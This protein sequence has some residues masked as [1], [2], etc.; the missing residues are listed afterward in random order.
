MPRRG[1]SFDV[2]R[3]CVVEPAR[4]RRIWGGSRQIVG[5][6][7]T[8]QYRGL[9]V[10]WRSRGRLRLGPGEI[11]LK[12][13]SPGFGVIWP[14]PRTGP[15][16]EVILALRSDCLWLSRGEPS[17]YCRDGSPWL[18][19]MCGAEIGIGAYYRSPMS[20]KNLMVSSLRWLIRPKM[21]SSSARDRIRDGL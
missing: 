20:R 19:L 2:P 12:G 21:A 3:Q 18:R 6:D 13:A 11:G 1:R 10:G 14:P 7:L 9:A 16:F 4:E 8:R 5:E 17:D 15:A